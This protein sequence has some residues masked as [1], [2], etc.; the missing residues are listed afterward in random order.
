MGVR[1]ACVYRSFGEEIGCIIEP[2]NAQTLYEG[3]GRT[4]RT[5]A[6]LAL[7]VLI[8][9]L[10]VVV[11]LIRFGKAI[12]LRVEVI[13]L[14]FGLDLDQRRCVFI[15]ARGSLV[16]PGFDNHTETTAADRAGVLAVTPGADAVEMEAVAVCV[17]QES[18]ECGA[19][20]EGS[21]WRDNSAHVC[22]LRISLWSYRRYEPANI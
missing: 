13:L 20:S 6:D 15:D 3:M 22:R 2:G 18:R 21:R 17:E 16:G 11:V 8:L 5:V 10:C 12:V 9:V 14:I 1:R 19:E 7:I 4:R